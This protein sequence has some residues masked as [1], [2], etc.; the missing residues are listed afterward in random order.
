M[1]P[2]IAAVWLLRL[3][4]LGCLYLFLATVVRA[5]VRDLRAV[6][7]GV[8]ASLGRL[9]VIEAPGGAPATGTRFPLGA[10]TT[11]G[12][13]VNNAIVL[14]DRFVSGTH[15]VLSFRGRT[16]YVEDLGSTNGTY[17]NGIRVEGPVPI[18]WGDELQVGA[19]R[20]RLEPSEP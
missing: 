14:E 15:A 12:R 3:T 19:I 5:L 8:P 6:A 9:A 11:L 16:W 13:D 1:D 2:A 7:R 20:L 4:F 17:V 18:G 10:I